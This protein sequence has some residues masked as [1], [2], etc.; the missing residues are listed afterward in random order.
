MRYYIPDNL[1][2]KELIELNHQNEFDWKNYNI[3]M[4]RNTTLE[5]IEHYIDKPWDWVQLSKNPNLTP[6][7]VAKHIDRPWEFGKYGLSSNRI[8]TPEFVEK[9][10]NKNWDWGYEGLGSNIKNIP[11]EFYEKHNIKYAYVFSHYITLDKVDKYINEV[12]WKFGAPGLSN[13]P[14]LTLK[15]I[16]K[17]IDKPW[18]WGEFGLSN[19]PIM[20]IDFF[21]KHKTKPWDERCITK[22]FIKETWPEYYDGQIKWGFSL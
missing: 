13:N 8:V 10:I 12:K 19:H 9:F 7:F 20:T 18:E 17:Y 14:N 6:D 11:F 5:F 16:E 22:L 15:F 1:S 21:E 3:T 2:L 4:N